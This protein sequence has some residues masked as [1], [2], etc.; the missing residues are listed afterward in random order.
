MQKKP[1]FITILFYVQVFIFPKTY[2]NNTQK[3]HLCQQILVLLMAFSLYFFTLLNNFLL[4]II[5][6]Y[7]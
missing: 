4:Y 1:F 5:I 7:I 3:C 6:L 2:Y